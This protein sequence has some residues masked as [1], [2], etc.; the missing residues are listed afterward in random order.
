M[1]ALTRRYRFNASHRLHSDALSEDA[2]WATY[3]RCNNPHGHGHEYVLEVMVEGDVDSV[4]GRVVDVGALDGLVQ[5]TVLR[6]FDHRDLNL[7]VP[8]LRGLVPTTEV[9]ADAVLARLMRAWPHE[10]APRLRG[11]RIYETRNNVFEAVLT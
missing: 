10:K 4:T 1:I 9:V 6:D 7:E 2:N 3:G 5:T 8:E 11:V